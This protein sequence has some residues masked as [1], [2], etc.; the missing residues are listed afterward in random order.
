MITVLGKKLFE[1]RYVFGF[2]EPLE[3]SA[4]AMVELGLRMLCEAFSAKQSTHG[5]SQ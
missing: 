5:N 3:A 1:L 4:I 2:V